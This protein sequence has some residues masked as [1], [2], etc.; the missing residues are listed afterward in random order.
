LE[1]LNRPIVVALLLVHGPEEMMQLGLVLR[2]F[3]ASLILLAR[4]AWCG[5]A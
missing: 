2:N 4:I 5:S 3:A 1:L